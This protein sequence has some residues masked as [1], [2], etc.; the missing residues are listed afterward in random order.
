MRRDDLDAE[1]VADDIAIDFF[2]LFRSGIGQRVLAQ[3]RQESA[4]EESYGLDIKN[5]ACPVKL[6]IKQGMA[7][8][9]LAIVE[10]VERGAELA[11]KKPI[12]KERLEEADAQT[13]MDDGLT[14]FG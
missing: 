6:A 11:T 12:D 1:K 9:Y 2:L 13:R 5:P 3:I 7:N 8:T 10:Q 4:I 14:R